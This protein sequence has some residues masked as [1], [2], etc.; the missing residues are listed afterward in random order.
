M[1]SLEAAALSVMMAVAGAP[2]SAAEVIDATLHWARRAELGMPVSGVVQEVYV[3]R[4]Q[5]VAAGQALVMLDPR[6]FEAR[7]A[8]ARAALAG[9][10]PALEEARDELERAEDLYD[11]T[12]ISEHDVE[13]VRIEVV[14]LEAKRQQAEARVARA[15]LRLERS[16][17]RAPF[18]GIVVARSVE[19]GEAL[20]SRFE[21]RTLVVI[22]DDRNFIARGLLPAGHLAGL[23]IGQQA[24]A[25]VGERSLIGTISAIAPEPLVEAA[26]GPRHEVDVLLPSPEDGGLRVGG[27]VRLE[28]P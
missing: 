26:A 28:L 12:L 17:L 9:V 13:V 5:Q 23:R 4:G 2:A 3:D 27:R 25:N 16:T 6:G 11:R 24:T 19:V 8:G 15:A 1:K 20:A 21:S 10:L 14:K 22:A 7:L 18:P